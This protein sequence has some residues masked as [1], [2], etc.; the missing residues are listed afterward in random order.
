MGSESAIVPVIN[1]R[2]PATIVN[3]VSN[4]AMDSLISN[5]LLLA[6]KNSRMVFKVPKRIE[7]PYSWVDHIP[8]AFFLVEILRPRILVELG[9][10][11]G[12]SFNAFCQAVDSLGL[13]THTYGVDTWEGDPHAGEYAVDCGGILARL[14]RHVS[15]NYLAFANLMKMTFD[16]SL[17]YFSDGS[18]DLLHI[19]GYHSYEAASHDFST[20]LSKMSDRGVVLLHDT[21]VRRT[22]FG[23]WRL[24]EELSQ[25]Y[26]S[27]QFSFGFGLG[28]VLVGQNTPTLVKDLVYANNSNGFYRQFFCN[29][30]RAIR[31]GVEKNDAV[32]QVS[33]TESELHHYRTLANADSKLNAR[34]TVSG[35]A[36]ISGVAGDEQIVTLGEIVFPA[37]ETKPHRFELNINP[38]LEIKQLLFFVDGR[39]IFSH[40]GIEIVKPDHELLKNFSAL[41]DLSRGANSFLFTDR[42]VP[43]LRIINTTPC[44]M[45]SIRGY[46]RIV[47]LEDDDIYREELEIVRQLER[48]SSMARWSNSSDIKDDLT[49]CQQRVLALLAELTG[50]EDRIVNYM[51]A[52]KGATND[53]TNYSENRQTKFCEEN[54]KF[55]DA[56]RRVSELEL[57][58]A[59]LKS[60]L[61]VRECQERER[62]VDLDN[63]NSSYIALKRQI[64]DIVNSKSWRITAPLRSMASLFK[65]S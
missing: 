54:L 26:E 56:L 4:Q 52:L 30:G 57:E 15:D 64:S 17:S 62:V 59:D 31:E 21:T 40:Y 8:F 44:Q 55:S 41:G 32:E 2:N 36:N 61:I 24:Y 39:G 16:E 9:V 23:V 1:V 50:F 25:Q 34:I 29:L 53:I 6:L 11:T 43:F 46:A 3:D 60:R 37:K 22:N 35:V 27:T 49:L 65:R 7:K 51:N 48:S 33:N 20:W 12:N 38:E 42:N 28:V 45:S 19:D 63:L 18:I 13:D 5:G 14:D 47:L 58:C 10:H